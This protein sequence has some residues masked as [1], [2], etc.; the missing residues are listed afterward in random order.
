MNLFCSDH[1][2]LNSF[3]LADTADLALLTAEAWNRLQLS[4]HHLR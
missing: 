1:F 3:R 4:L 2:A